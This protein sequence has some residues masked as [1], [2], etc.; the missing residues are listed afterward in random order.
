MKQ[1]WN[2]LEAWQKG[3]IIGVIFALITSVMNIGVVV[4]FFSTSFAMTAVAFA[5]IGAV[6][7]IIVD[8]K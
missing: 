5:L 6:I 8:K 4:G 3:G 7:G 2:K 1:N